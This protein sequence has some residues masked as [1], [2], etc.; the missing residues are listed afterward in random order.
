MGESPDLI[1]EK[2]KSG[3]LVLPTPKT[4]ILSIQEAARILRVSTKTLRRWEQR[5]LLVPE[6]TFGNH[7]RYTKE[8]IQEFKVKSKERKL[9]TSA[10]I[11]PQAHVT[12]QPTLPDQSV[13]IPQGTLVDRILAEEN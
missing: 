8:Q 11:Q 2:Q 9:D 3:G 12:H 1:G 5:G 13:Q 7:R 4:N 6:R 10:S